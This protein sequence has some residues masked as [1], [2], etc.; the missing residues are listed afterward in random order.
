MLN[1]VLNNQ[2]KFSSNIHILFYVNVQNKILVDH[3]RKEPKINYATLLLSFERVV[4][5]VLSQQGVWVGIHKTS[6]KT[7]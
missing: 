3:I 6:Y 4:L 1:L 2:T 5:C 7:S